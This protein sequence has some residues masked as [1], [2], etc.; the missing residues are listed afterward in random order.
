VNSNA[1]VRN[2][3][4]N[5]FTVTKDTTAPTATI[6][7]PT[8]LSDG[9]FTDL[10]SILVSV[11]WSEPIEGFAAGSPSAD[12]TVNVVDKDGVSATLATSAD[13][14]VYYNNITS[15]VDAASPEDLDCAQK[16][17][18]DGFQRNAE[19]TVS[20]NAN[21]DVLTVF[22]PA[23]AAFDRANTVNTV[24]NSLTLKY[25]QFLGIPT[26]DLHSPDAG[27]YYKTNASPYTLTATFSEP[28]TGFAA[29]SVS[30]RPEIK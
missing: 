22:I 21:G 7:L 30:V 15:G 19:F 20:P 6:S 23:G 11:V 16:F 4:S 14:F 24:S 25:D 10:T 8:G 29:A 26:V 1:G 17:A 2:L 5:T 12:V 9:D 18:A 28:V 3:V 27:K 13:N